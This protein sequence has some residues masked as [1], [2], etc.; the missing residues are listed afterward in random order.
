[1]VRCDLKCLSERT[2]RWALVYRLGLLVG[3]NNKGD[4]ADIILPARIVESG[5]P[6]AENIANGKLAAICMQVKFTTVGFN[7]SSV[8]AA[9]AGTRLGMDGDVTVVPIVVLLQSRDAAD[10]SFDKVISDEK[11]VLASHQGRILHA[12]LPEFK[13]LSLYEE[14][15]LSS[16]MVFDKVPSQPSASSASSAVAVV[17]E[18]VGRPKKVP[19]LA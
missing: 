4:V 8:S 5:N 12:I 11:L 14:M 3:A 19:K 16:V 15:R 9:F 18:D 7:T 1:M 17:N 10:A 13:K 6:T 2:L